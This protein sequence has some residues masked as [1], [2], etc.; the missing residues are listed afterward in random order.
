MST[1][2]R[3]A[4]RLK[5]RLSYASISAYG[6]LSPRFGY[7]FE[8]LRKNG[9]LRDHHLGLRLDAFVE[10]RLEHNG[11]PVDFELA[12]VPVVL[13]GVLPALLRRQ[14]SA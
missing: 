14:L 4:L 6:K 2:Y 1:E 11:T 10:N 5:E 12:D 8:A 7:A 9:L 13:G 3:L